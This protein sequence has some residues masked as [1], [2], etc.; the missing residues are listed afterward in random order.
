MKSRTLIPEED[1]ASLRSRNTL[2]ILF[3]KHVSSPHDPSSC[4]S[5]LF[6]LRQSTLFPSTL[7][8]HRHH[9]RH[10]WTHDE[11]RGKSVQI[12]RRSRAGNILKGNEKS[13][14]LSFS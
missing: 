13:P 9:R 3:L 4:V 6:T 7:K 14:L 11:K 10:F 8:N 5:S 1:H 2:E 12:E